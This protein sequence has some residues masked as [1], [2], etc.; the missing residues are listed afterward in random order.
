MPRKSNNS[1][2][3]PTGTTR[4]SRTNNMVPKG[5]SSRNVSFRSRSRSRSPLVRGMNDNLNGGYWSTDAQ[6]NQM[7]SV[8]L[9]RMN[10][11]QRRER[12]LC[13]LERRVREREKEVSKREGKLV[14]E[15][16]NAIQEPRPRQSRMDWSDNSIPT[17]R[18]HLASDVRGRCPEFDGTKG[19]YDVW[20][21]SVNAFLNMYNLPEA[22]KIK[23]VNSGLRGVAREFMNTLEATS[24]TN[25]NALD[26]MLRKTFYKQASWV[27]ELQSMTQK[28]EES[29]AAFQ[30]RVEVVAK[31]CTAQPA[32]L[33]ELCSSAFRSGLLPHLKKSL[34]VRL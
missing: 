9:E 4:V 29:V 32:E 31:R 25:M 10:D 28:V 2:R 20:W 30:V 3:T 11:F 13:E 16:R 6:S 26:L 1:R 21:S 24:I 8:T 22:E 34:T 23:V 12:E 18:V 33:D 14:Q 5:A 15:S 19:D 27:V 17:P 7:T